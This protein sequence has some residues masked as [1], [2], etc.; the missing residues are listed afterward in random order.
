M[1]NCVTLTGRLTAEPELRVAQSGTQV[2]RFR[3][4]VERNTAERIADFL[5]VIC[6]ASTAEFVSKY[7]QKGS[8]IAVQGR[9][10]TGS[11]TDN[12]GV[13]RSTFE[14][15]ATEVSFCAGKNTQ[16]AQ[17][18]CESTNST[19]EGKDENGYFSTAD[20]GDF[21]EIPDDEDLPF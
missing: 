1:L 2:C 12:K 11:Y 17:K 3:V 21:D 8:M 10:Q 14:I 5:Q 18:P 15:V 9:I 19:D 6:F 7:F 13:K 20:P 16:Q 4:A